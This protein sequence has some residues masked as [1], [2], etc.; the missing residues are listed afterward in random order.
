MNLDDYFFLGTI[1]RT[2]KLQG[3]VIAFFDVDDLSKYQKLD[4][5]FI[6]SGTTLIPHEIKKIKLHDKS[7]IIDLNDVTSVEEAES[8]VGKNL[9]LP[10]NKLPK[11]EG[12]QFYFH[13]VVG[14]TAMDE[15]AGEIGII[16]E[17][18][19][20]PGQTLAKINHKGKEVL[21]PLTLAW[22]KKVD[23]ENKRLTYSL[24]NGYLDVYL[25]ERTS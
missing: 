19:E 3:A 5:V 7:F 14:F 18:Q 8:L 10:L 1:Q 11:L 21:L 2:Y 16:E 22:I 25:S 4:W 23:R 15:T 13:E 20:F 6:E 12:N 9:Y 24:P 17:L